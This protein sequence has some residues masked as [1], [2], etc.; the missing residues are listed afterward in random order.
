MTLNKES[1]EQSVTQPKCANCDYHIQESYLFC[2]HCGQRTRQSKLTAWFLITDFFASIFNFDSRVFKTIRKIIIPGRLASEYLMGRRKSY[3]NPSRFF[4]LCLIIHFAVLAYVINNT[5]LADRLNN[6]K[7]ENAEKLNKTEMVK[8]FDDVMSQR[9]MDTLEVASLRDSLFGNVSNSPQDTFSL[10]KN[11]S[12]AGIDLS[13]FHITTRDFAFL[14]ATEIVEKYGINNSWEKN[15][16]RQIKKMWNDPYGTVQY[17]I[18]NFL[19]AIVLLVIF[20]ALLL[21]LL[22]IRSSYYIVEHLILSISYHSVVLLILAIVYLTTEIEKS[23]SNS[24]EISIMSGDI[25]SSIAFILMNIYVFFS[26][27]NF[28]KQGYIKTLIK[29]SLLC[30]YELVLVITFASIILIISMFIF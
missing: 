12:V 1:S 11:F 30:F 25:V 20:S 24:Y 22:Y 28:Y 23:D 27:K 3:L 29:Y 6:F 8:T 15:F 17:L 14:S 9:E 2:H 18:G 21:K 13:R 4:F 26:I 7:Q 16:L 19:W 5:S 10:L